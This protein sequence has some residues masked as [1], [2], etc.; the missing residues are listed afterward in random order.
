M[1]MI[2][3]YTSFGCSSAIKAKEWLIQHNIGFVEKNISRTLLN[4]EEIKYILQRCPNGTDDIIST[5]SRVFKKLGTCIDELS[6]NDL[7]NF[8]QE[9]PTILKRP[10]LMDTTNFIVGY[11]DDEITTFISHDT[12]TKTTYQRT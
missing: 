8:I 2:L 3:M 11:D 6:M 5:R 9:N 4:K 10:I 7:I 12:R 1:N